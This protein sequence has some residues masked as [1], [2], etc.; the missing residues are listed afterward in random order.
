MGFFG[1][2]RKRTKSVRAQINKVKH[3]IQKK[4]DRALLASLRKQLR[5][6]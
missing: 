4:K 6:Y 2:S 3:Q 5:G 1:S